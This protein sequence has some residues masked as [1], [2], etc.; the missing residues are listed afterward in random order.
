VPSTG[1]IE[2]GGHLCWKEE[3]EGGVHKKKKN[4][5]FMKGKKAKNK[6]AVNE[7]ERKSPW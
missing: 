4:L 2:Q 3:R 6:R 1:K 7:G 5:G